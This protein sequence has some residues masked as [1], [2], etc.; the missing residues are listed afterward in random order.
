[1]KESESICLKYPDHKLGPYVRVGVPHTPT[2]P[3]VGNKLQPIRTTDST[4]GG[5]WTLTKR[6]FQNAHVQKVIN[7]GS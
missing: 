2:L 3:I 4:V 5:H 1:M 6:L 7:S